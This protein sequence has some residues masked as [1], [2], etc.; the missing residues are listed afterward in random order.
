MR[1]LY[2]DEAGCLGALPSLISDIQ[3]VFVIAGVSFDVSHLGD[4][5]RDFIALKRRFFPGAH[6]SLYQLDA[7]LVEVKGAD[8]RRNASIGGHRSRRAAFGFLDGVLYLVDQHDGKFFGRIWIKGIGVPFDG[9]SVYTF[10]MQDICTTFQRSLEAI[11]EQGFVV[12]DSRSKPV[13]T[14]VSHSVFTMKF[15]AV[16]DAFPNLLE[17]PLFGHS[18][19][20]AGIQIAD[21]LCSALL[22]PMAVQT[23]CAGHITSVH[24]RNYAALKARYMTHLRRSQFRYQDP[25]GWWRGGF[26]VSDEIAHRNGAELFR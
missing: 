18:D 1:V 24:V 19:N 16:G 23:Y 2:I 4:I 3:P 12:A 25:S 13:N 8:I 20:H 22:F 21:L 7:I 5:T 26:T 15:Q 10:S 9:R 14:N 17:M 11:G 6:T